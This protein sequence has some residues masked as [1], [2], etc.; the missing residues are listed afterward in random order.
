MSRYYHWS[1]GFFVFAA[2]ILVQG[3]PN[4]LAYLDQ[5][6]IDQQ[7]SVLSIVANNPRPLAQV[8]DGLAKRYGWNLSYEDPRFDI[9]EDARSGPN[10]GAFS[11]SVPD[12]N[13]TEPKNKSRTLDAILKAYNGSPNP[14]RF[15][16]RGFDDGTF[17]AV[18][19]AA[20]HG[21]QIPIMDTKITLRT[22]NVPAY[23][24]LDQWSH[25][26]SRSGGIHIE[27]AG[28]ADNGLARAKVTVEA[29]NATAR[30]ALRQIIGAAGSNRRWLFY[31]NAV[32]RF[33]MLNLMNIQREE[34]HVVPSANQT[35]A[36]A[37]TDKSL[38]AQGKSRYLDYKCGDCHGAN[39]EGGADGP[40]LT[41]TYMD[42]GQISRFLENPSPDAYMKGMPNIPAKH[43]DHQALVAYVL[44]LKR[45]PTQ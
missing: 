17:V 38:I 11:V 36:T 1:I 21:G 3:T 39:G 27:F 18:G 10:G 45:P 42:A 5:A 7:G 12:F 34:V 13:L 26:L 4:P 20:A 14:G 33:Y 19:V 37:L 44:S 8:F 43:P 22:E 31:F 16:L 23:E 15:E 28:I 32:G 29:E 24:A 2:I 9:P 35:V 30:D 6:Q 41:T 40:E 25:A